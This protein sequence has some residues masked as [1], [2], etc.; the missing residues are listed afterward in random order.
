MLHTLSCFYRKD[1]VWRAQELWHGDPYLTVKQALSYMKKR[2]AV[3]CSRCRKDWLDL[4]LVPTEEVC[5]ICHLTSCDH[6]I[7]R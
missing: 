1:G 6:D 5:P 3:A 4:V 7:E 2:G